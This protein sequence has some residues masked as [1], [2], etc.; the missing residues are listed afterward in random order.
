MSVNAAGSL[1]IRRVQ[2]DA[3]YKAFFE[4]PWTVYND[5]PNWVPPLLSIRHTLLD[6]KKNPSWE[7][8]E[9][10]FF[11]AYRGTQPVG[12]I[13]AF[14]NHN[15]NKFWNVKVGWF[16]FFECVNDQEVATGLLN[17]AGDHIRSLGPY[18]TMLGPAQYTMN[19]EC[20]MLIENFT[21]PVLLMP[22]NKPYYPQLVENS[23]LTKAMD[24][25]SWYSNPDTIQSEGGMPA[26][27]VRV[28][29]KTS[30]RNGIKIRKGDATHLREELLI[31][32]TIW[33][34]AWEKNWGFQPPTDRELDLLFKDLKDYFDPALGRIAEIDG[35]AVGFLLALPDMNQVLKLGYAHPGEPEFVTLI[36][37][38]W[39]WKIRPK[40][41]GQRI[42]LM[43]VIPE[44][45]GKGVDA[46]MNLSF[47]QEAVHG[48]YPDTDA[49]WVLETNQPMN[50]L[51]ISF[52]AKLYKRYRVYEKK[53]D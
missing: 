46:A 53:L 27:L 24:L 52:H 32:R 16:G 31:I 38:L 6:K 39:H 37:I 12:T 7:Y 49:G 21:Q 23:G 15:Y 13:A 33:E 9:G 43:G 41:T 42:L 51:A 45:R 22:Y 18:T 3:D 19:D 29:E 35:K 36:K 20:G 26:K 8:L 4:F 17:A 2:N 44:Y 47:F 11:V 34:S 14:I 10:D 25:N 1:T 48:K 30:A 50:Q 5:D 28:V 40:I